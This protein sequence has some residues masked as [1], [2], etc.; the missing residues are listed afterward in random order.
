MAA[1][2]PCSRCAVSARCGH[3]LRRH[4][5]VPP[6]LGQEVWFEAGEGPQARRTAGH[7]RAW[8]TRSR[9]DRPAFGDRR[10]AGPGPRRAG[11]GTRPD[12]FR[13]RTLDGRHLHDRGP[14]SI[15]RG[16][17]T[18]AYDHPEKLDA[19]LD[20]LVDSTARY[21]VMQ[22]KSGAQVLKIFESWAEGLAEDVFERIV[23]S[24]TRR[25]S[26]RFARRRRHR[27]V[28]RLSAW[29]RG[30]GRQ[31]RRGGSGE[32]ASRSTPR[33]AP[34]LASGCRLAG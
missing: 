7:S 23:I 3:R 12:R 29:G 26:R 9:L 25:S 16:A 5:A 28:H 11:A 34:R 19:L 22:A 20:V 14:G 33:P 1:K 24:R 15:G 31:L 10:D 21:L 18:F 17:R 13:R 30:A 27:A 6:A 4:P 32:R 8:P 2:P